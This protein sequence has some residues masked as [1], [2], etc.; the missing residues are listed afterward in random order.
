MKTTKLVPRFPPRDRRAEPVLCGDRRRGR[1]I[2]RTG[3]QVR[4]DACLAIFR[5]AQQP[6][7]PRIRSAGAAALI[8]RRLSRTS[9]VRSRYRGGRWRKSS[10]G[11]SAR[12]SG[13]VTVIGAPVNQAARLCELAKERSWTCGGI[14][15]KRCA[16]TG[17]SGKRSLDLGDTVTLRG[18][19]GVHECLRCHGIR[20]TYLTDRRSCNFGGLSL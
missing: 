20:S 7:A 2:R 10:Q 3:Q 18:L 5:C 8:T 14:R 17:G 16:V 12:T 1:P 4:G 9:R 15:Q 19:S 11:T 6:G 13:S